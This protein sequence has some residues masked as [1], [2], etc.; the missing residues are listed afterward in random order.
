MVADTSCNAYNENIK[1]FE[2]YMQLQGDN[3]TK[4]GLL[5]SVKVELTPA[6]SWTSPPGVFT[7]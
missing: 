3:W 2:R 1:C 5:L 7:S 6:A 4:S